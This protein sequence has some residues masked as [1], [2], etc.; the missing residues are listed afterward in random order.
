MYG[1]LRTADGSS[2][3][4]HS[5][6]ALF[7]LIGFMGIDF[8]IGLAFLWLIARELAHGPGLPAG[9]KTEVAHG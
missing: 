9:V 2:P 4:V 6:T 7:T 1:I 8:V 3:T 5:G